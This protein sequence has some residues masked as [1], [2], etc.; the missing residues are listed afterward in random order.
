MTPI[1]D[2]TNKDVSTEEAAQNCLDNPQVLQELLEG[3]SSRQDDE[4]Y[5]SFKVVLLV[6]EQ[7]PDALY[8]YWNHFEE[9][10]RGPNG[11]SQTI[12][13][14]ILANLVLI[15]SKNK[16]EPIFERYFG[17]LSGDKTVIAASIAANA[18]KIAISQPD[19]MSKVTEKLLSIDRIH[20]GK[21][22]DLIK[23][24]ALEAFGHYFDK[25]DSKD[26]KQI[27]EFVK[28]Q[29][30]SKSPRTQKAAKEF[31]KARE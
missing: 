24:H 8:A 17:F 4:L 16:F 14:Q 29:T 25:A 21:Q 28:A 3:L 31:L 2:L 19:L 5:S 26:K 27:L 7:H 6:S 22:K 18:W 11:N 15:D 1:S 9:M 13:V 23:G 12:A 10:L 20:Q 30:H